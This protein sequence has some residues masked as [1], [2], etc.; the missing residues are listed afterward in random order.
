MAPLRGV[1]LIGIELQGR[2][3]SRRLLP[4]RGCPD[5]RAGGPHHRDTPQPVPRKSTDRAN[6]DRVPTTVDYMY[7]I[8]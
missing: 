8:D 4:T 5:R 6:A 2:A 3:S 1:R 7:V